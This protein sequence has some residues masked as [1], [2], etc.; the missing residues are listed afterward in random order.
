MAAK[1]RADHSHKSIL[2]LWGVVYWF[3][4]AFVTCYWFVFFLFV[5]CLYCGVEELQ[6]GFCRFCVVTSSCC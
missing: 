3:S 5:C 2:V 1:E 6:S 4:V